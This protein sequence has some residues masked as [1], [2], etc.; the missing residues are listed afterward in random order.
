MGGAGSVKRKKHPT[1]KEKELYEQLEAQIALNE[2]KTETIERL[3]DEL[4]KHDKDLDAVKE[5]ARSRSRELDSLQVELQ[6]TKRS[7]A[8]AERNLARAMGYIDRVNEG[9]KELVVPE[10]YSQRIIELGPKLD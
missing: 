4:V 6:E 5:S 3:K 2:A 8:N 1:S 10:A 9:Q 7:L